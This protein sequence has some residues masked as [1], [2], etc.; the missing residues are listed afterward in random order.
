MKG[1]AKSPQFFDGKERDTLHFHFP[2]LNG[3]VSTILRGPW[4]PEKHLRK[5]TANE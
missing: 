2:I 3:A 5:K 1:Q 4:L